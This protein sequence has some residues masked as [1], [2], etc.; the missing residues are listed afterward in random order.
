MACFPAKTPLIS[1]ISVP[2]L[3]VDPKKFSVLEEI[4]FINSFFLDSKHQYVKLYLDSNE[5]RNKRVALNKMSLYES[6]I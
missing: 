4:E 1:I 5:F 6:T 3:K 2:D